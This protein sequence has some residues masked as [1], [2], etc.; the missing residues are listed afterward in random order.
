MSQ[1]VTV[2]KDRS[3]EWTAADATRLINDPV[4]KECFDAYEKA[5]VERAIEAPARDDDARTRCMMAI[6]TLRRVRKHLDRLIF[7]GK[8]AA[9]QAADNIAT[10]EDQWS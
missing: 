5:L 1:A 9:M 7:D 3:P 4:L 10:G 8:S 6:Q 2:E